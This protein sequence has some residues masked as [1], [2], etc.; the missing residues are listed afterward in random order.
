MLLGGSPGLQQDPLNLGAL[1]DQ[2]C[3]G[4]CYVPH[5]THT[6]PVSPECLRTP[7]LKTVHIP[8]ENENIRNAS[9]AKEHINSSKTKC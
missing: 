4:R 1:M 3:S 8:S 7:T 6:P 5:L 9:G 2:C